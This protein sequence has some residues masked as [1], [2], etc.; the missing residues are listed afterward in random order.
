[1][2]RSCSCV[3]EA[4]AWRNASARILDKLVRRRARDRGVKRMSAPGSVSPNVVTPRATPTSMSTLPP[5]P[6]PSVPLDH[7]GHPSIFEMEPAQTWAQHRLL[8]SGLL[9]AGDGTMVGSGLGQRMNVMRVVDEA[10]GIALPVVLKAVD[11]GGPQEVFAW[12]VAHALGIER[13]LPLVGSRP[14]GAAAVQYIPGRSLGDVRAVTARGMESLF[15][16]VHQARSPARAPADWLQQARID[17]QLAQAFDYAIANGDRHPGNGVVVQR[18][19]PDLRLIDHALLDRY[20]AAADGLVPTLR[21]FYMSTPD[22]VHEGR[23]V[24]A[25]R[26]DPA[27]QERFRSAD[28]HAIRRAFND[29]HAAAGPQNGKRPAYLEQLLRRVAVVAETGVLRF[30]LM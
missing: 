12:R 13:M 6:T 17:R 23:G 3:L 27:V 30:T 18:G 10:S 22:A 2:S 4:A 14:D 5:A 9:T 24:R 20:P 7:A 15:E 21:P 19:N 25:L 8:S 26:L 11:K 28:L 1:M 29:L 16:Q